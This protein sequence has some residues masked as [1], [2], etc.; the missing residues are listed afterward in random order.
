MPIPKRKRARP[1]GACCPPRP[2]L[3]DRPLL[4][5]LDAVKVM[6]LFKMMAND[7]V[8]FAASSERSARTRS[9][10]TVV[11]RGIGGSAILRRHAVTPVRA[12]LSDLSDLSDLS[13][14]FQCPSCCQRLASSARNGQE[15]DALRP[16]SK[17]KSRSL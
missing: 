17:H 6:A 16:E 9:R 8:S 10:S 7:R 5:F 3:Q 4:S 1:S 14:V 13:C 11:T 12:S 2:P 15:K